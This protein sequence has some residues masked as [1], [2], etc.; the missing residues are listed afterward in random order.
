MTNR[1]ERKLSGQCC[2]VASA[3]AKFCKSGYFQ[4][5]MASKNFNGLQL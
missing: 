2:Q 1:G 3:E 5:S 4:N